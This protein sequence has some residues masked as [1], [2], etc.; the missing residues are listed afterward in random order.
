[1]NVRA[2]VCTTFQSGTNPTG[3][4]IPVLDGDV[5]L[6]AGADIRSTLELVTD[7][8]RMWP[9]RDSLL[10]APYGNEVFVERGVQFGGG[11]TEWCSLG[12]FRIDTPSQDA[13]PDGPIR[14]SGSDRMAGIVDARLT[15]PRQFQSFTIY[16]DV[17]RL[18][19]QEVYPT[20]TI[21]WDDSTSDQQIGRTL[22]VEEDR[23]AALK[24]L[25]TSI[26][27]I[28]YWDYRGWLQVR[29]PPNPSVP[30]FDVTHGAGG[31][32]VSM[33]RELSRDGVY[34]AVVAFGEAAD[35]TAPPR[36]MAVDANPNSPTY[37]DGTFGKVPRFYSSPFITTDAQAQSAAVAI[38]RQSLGLPYS[39]DFTAVPN[40]ALEP[41]DPVR[42]SYADR[43]GA[44]THVID[45]LTI[46]LAAQGAMTATTREQTVVIVGGS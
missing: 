44:E 39:V 12:Y 18:L 13:P 25:V 36:A 22:L 43:A 1:M 34:N 21:I 19:V 6:D 35:T 45:T 32:L 37:W 9:G 23:Y 31:V 17:V 3:T 8:A 20:A 40:P 46:P 26:G 10:L 2:R 38:L 15:T 11:T 16:W 7:G 24:D 29:T 28:F 42:I 4:V 30:V 5:Q 14:I 27:K 41:W 33:S